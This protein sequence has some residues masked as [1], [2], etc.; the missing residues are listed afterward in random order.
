MIKSN[1]YLKR[2]GRLTSSKAKKKEEVTLLFF[3]GLLPGLDDLLD[4]LGALRAV[5]QSAVARTVDDDDTGLRRRV[6]LEEHDVTVLGANQDAAASHVVDELDPPALGQADG[7][8]ALDPP[9][10][11]ARSVLP[12]RVE[13]DDLFDRVKEVVEDRQGGLFLG[14]RQGGDGEVRLLHGH[15]VSPVHWHRL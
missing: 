11:I 6:A 13:R 2:L 5:F 8:V 10:K 3:A 7:G 15:D 4:H 14:G 12:S 9:V 1:S